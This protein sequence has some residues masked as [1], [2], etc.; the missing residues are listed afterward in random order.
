MN[1]G[2][3]NAIDY[4]PQNLEL[5]KHKGI[6]ITLLPKDSIGLLQS[7]KLKKDILGNS[8][9]GKPSLGAIEPMR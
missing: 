4:I 8:I 7:I 6:D 9:I 3:I 1:K 5:V 2:G